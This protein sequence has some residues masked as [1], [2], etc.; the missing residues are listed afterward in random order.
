MIGV[1]SF[2]FLIIVIVL[3]VIAIF[4]FIKSYFYKKHI[5]QDNNARGAS[6]VQGTTL[7]LTCPSGKA[8]SVSN[9]TL[10]CTNPNSNGFEDS[11]CDPFYNTDGTRFNTANTI[12]NTS[13][14]ANQCNGKQTCQYTI[15]SSSSSSV[16]GICSGN[17]NTSC[18]GQ[19]QMIGSYVC[20]Q[21]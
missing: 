2:S 6:G 8:I 20:T 1:S 18:G 9:A 12:V 4:I 3:L 19:I 11:S 7:N 5:L 15:P 10:I 17:S 21:A 14:L 16:S 13:T